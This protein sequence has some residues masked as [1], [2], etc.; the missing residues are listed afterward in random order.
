MGVNY[1]FGDYCLERR[2]AEA[3]KFAHLPKN[4]L[5]YA[6]HLDATAYG[7]LLRKYSETSGVKR[8]EGKIASVNTSAETGFIEAL[9]MESGQLVS[10]DLFI[11]CTGF[12][13]L[14]EQS[15]SIPRRK[16]LLGE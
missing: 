13:G 11:D 9:V 14:L 16:T 8:V 5:K 7:Q 6:Y 3:G 4:G 12:R 15:E 2:A 1:G 10:G